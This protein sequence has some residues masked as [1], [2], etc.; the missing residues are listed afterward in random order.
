MALIDT[1]EEL[2]RHNS[3][4]TVGL[5]VKSLESFLADAYDKKII[6]AIGRAQF[7]ALVNGKAD[8][9]AGSNQE[10]LLHLVQKAAVNFA[11]GFYVA[12][13]S[14]LLNNSGAQV[15]TSESMKPASDKKLMALRRQS[16]ADAYTALEQA[17]EFL[18][19]NL[20]AFTDYANA[21][22]HYLNR[23][24]FINSSIEFN[25]ISGIR[26]DAQLYDSL[27]N[28]LQGIE[29]D[30][31]K[32]VVGEDLFD[33]LKQK[34]LNGN[35]TDDEK[36]LIKRIQKV[37]APLTIAEAIPYKLIRIE[38]GGIFQLSDTVGGISGNVENKTPANEMAVQAAMVKLC[39]KGESELESLR[40]WLNANADKFSDYVVQK[41]KG[42]VNVNTAGSG[43]YYL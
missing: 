42:E 10:T 21:T 4:V 12:Y 26:V 25:T 18:E 24:L 2:K 35:A 8:F 39:S 32:V 23:A 1:T 33:A 43:L 15:S 41:S 28:H 22:A 5:Q 7:N 20:G 17:V 16:I 27:R 34:V 40:K 6:P 30:Q 13:G 31:I 29:D 14:V 9:E 38:E 3:S 37:L 36:A 11:I 19:E